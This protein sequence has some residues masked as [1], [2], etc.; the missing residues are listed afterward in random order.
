MLQQLGFALLCIVT[1]LLIIT[2]TLLIILKLWSLCQNNNGFVS[3]CY[4]KFANLFLFFLQCLCFP[5]VLFQILV[6]PKHIFNDRYLN[7]GMAVYLIIVTSVLI[8]SWYTIIF[9]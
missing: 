8:Y 2:G 1:F 3:D 9:V 4:L 6:F 7:R 5:Y